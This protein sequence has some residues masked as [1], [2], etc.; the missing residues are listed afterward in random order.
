MHLIKVNAI[1]STNSFAREM[2][3]ENPKMAATCI[4]AEKQLQGRGQRGTSWTSEPGKNLT[5]SVIFPAPQVTPARQFIISAAVAVAIVK[6]LEKYQVPKLMIKWPNDI[7]AA[8]L[9]IGGLLIE[10]II[11]EGK[12]AAA[13]IGFGL[14]VNQ[15]EFPDLPAAG[16][17]RKATGDT[18]DLEEVLNSILVELEEN[19]KVISEGAAE[20]IL[21]EYK[22]RLFRMKVP[23]TF[24]LPEGYFFTGR[25]EDV[26]PSGKLVVETEEQVY[27]EYDLKEIKLCY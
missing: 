3:R 18:Y 13:I 20:K 27:K 24:Q 1:N 6:A 11:S 17:L 26:S 8:N 7:M 21:E 12:I 16:S 14:N 25:I 19:F 4:W 9:K 22:N 10:N 23:S 5:I 15:L 2:F